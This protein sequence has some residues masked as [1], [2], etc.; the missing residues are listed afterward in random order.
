MRRRRRP[1][2]DARMPQVAFTSVIYDA[3]RNIGQARERY[4]RISY[5]YDGRRC[6]RF[7][8][9]SKAFAVASGDVLSMQMKAGLP[10]DFPA[11]CRRIGAG[12]RYREDDSRLLTPLWLLACR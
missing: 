6:A 3:E 5:M 11:F 8:T 9:L 4:C 2:T 1:K 7:T 10:A 12:F